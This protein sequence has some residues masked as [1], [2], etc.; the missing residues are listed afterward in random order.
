MGCDARFLSLVRKRWDVGLIPRWIPMTVRQCL[1]LGV[2]DC[3]PSE[4]ESKRK[5]YAY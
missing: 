3:S 1:M 4:K 2:K 5:C